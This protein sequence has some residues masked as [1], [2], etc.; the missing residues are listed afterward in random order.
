MEKSRPSF[1]RWKQKCWCAD[2]ARVEQ[3][4][5]SFLL[6]ET[7]PLDDRVEFAVRILHPDETPA[8]TPH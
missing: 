4:A 6:D 3:S 5:A 7:I 2:A 1:V 8:R